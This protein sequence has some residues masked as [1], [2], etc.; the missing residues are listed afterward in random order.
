MKECI[1]DVITM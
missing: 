1:V